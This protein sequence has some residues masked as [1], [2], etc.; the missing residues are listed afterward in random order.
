MLMCR[1][2]D[3]YTASH[4]KQVLTEYIRTNEKDLVNEQNPRHSH[5]APCSNVSI[6]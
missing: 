5:F 4:I 3:L 2:D 1:K 6:D